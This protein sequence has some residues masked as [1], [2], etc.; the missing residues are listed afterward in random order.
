[1]VDV[2]IVVPKMNSTKTAPEIWTLTTVSL[3]ILLVFYPMTIAPI[4]TYSNGGILGLSSLL[5]AAFC[6]WAAFIRGRER[7]VVRWILLL[8]IAIVVTWAAVWD[9]VAQHH[10]GWW[11]GF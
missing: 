9:G 1:M 3:V 7:P 5:V 4:G 6:S 10:S 8:P 2:L 11:R